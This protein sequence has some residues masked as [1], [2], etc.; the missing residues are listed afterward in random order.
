MLEPI[1]VEDSTIT[2][3][4][5]SLEGILKDLNEY[6]TFHDYFVALLIVFLAESGFYESST[7]RSDLQCPRLRSLRI[8]KHWKSEET[9]IY[10]ISF[11]LEAFPDVKCKLVAIPS[12]DTLII[13]FFPLM[14]EKTTYCICVQTLMYVNPFSSD[15]CGRY[16]NLKAIS[17]RFKDVLATPVR[18]DVLTKAGSMGPSLQGLPTELK[19]KILKPLLWR[20][21]LQ[22]DYPREYTSWIPTDNNIQSTYRALKRSR[23]IR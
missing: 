16:R 23:K 20:K 1:L 4:V 11:Q 3:L 9:G 22:R 15:I 12:G 18:T 19:H 7:D 10:D 13:N 2:K 8:P 6:A 17:H 21:L 5:P 14:E